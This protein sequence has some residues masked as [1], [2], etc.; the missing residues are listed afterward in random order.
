MNR[1]N[2]VCDETVVT[3]LRELGEACARPN[4]RRWPA[5]A[6]TVLILFGIGCSSGSDSAA[7]GGEVDGGEV[8]AGHDGGMGG[9]PECTPQKATRW[10]WSK[11]FT[12]AG[13]RTGPDDSIY[14]LTTTIAPAGDLLS[15]LPEDGSERWRASYATDFDDV[16]ATSTVVVAKTSDHDLRALNVAD[17]SKLWD[18][19]AGSDVYITKISA[20]VDGA[21][22][23]LSSYEGLKAIDTH[24]G[25]D[26]WVVGV[27]WGGKPSTGIDFGTPV[28]GFGQFADRLFVVDEFN[29]WAL[30]I[31]DGS[32]LWEKDGGDGFGS[33]AGSGTPALAAGMLLVPNSDGK[34]YA[35][36]P[37]DGSGKWAVTICVPPVLSYGRPPFGLQ[38]S[39]SGAVYVWAQ[40]KVSLLSPN[41]G[42]LQWSVELPVTGGADDK[43]PI[44]SL[45]IDADG[46]AYVLS[47]KDFLMTGGNSIFK[48]DRANGSI[49]WSYTVK[50]DEIM[51][52]ISLTSKN[53]VLGSHPVGGSYPTVGGVVALSKYK[54]QSTTTCEPCFRLCD[55]NDQ[56]AQC[57]ADGA[58]WGEVVAC[59]ESQKCWVGTC[60]D[61]ALKASKRCKDGDVWWVDGCGRVETLAEECPP[62][63]KCSDGECSGG[64]TV[65]ELSDC[66]ETGFTYS[67]GSGESQTSYSYGGPGPNGVSSAV[68]SFSNGHIV[69]CTYTSSGSGTCR[70][71]GV[72]T[73]SF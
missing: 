58:A 10:D 55:E 68:T 56:V 27:Q 33:G 47:S 20:S 19:H 31:S 28:A 6:A 48:L 34:L 22:L 30:R 35:L 24:T 60:A 3:V 17:G 25:N 49:L 23:F 53:I 38:A 62:P 4:P 67:C 54:N 21:T 12:N 65:C 32:S 44:D 2:G 64:S 41:N 61:C 8:S 51:G 52:S 39:Q 59:S 14:V 50:D 13:I 43:P 29:L 36:N 18:Y 73:C 11:A 69:T 26:R 57:A 72:A 71:D 40:N 1:S 15:L 63:Q 46:T 16:F 45:L 5:A 70:D 42:A 66:S 9:L 7:N 37:A